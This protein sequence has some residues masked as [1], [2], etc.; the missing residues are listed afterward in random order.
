MMSPSKRARL[1]ALALLPLAAPALSAQEGSREAYS[2][3]AVRVVARP[4]IDGVLD[5]AIWQTA[6]VIDAFIQQEPSEGAPA[7]ERTEVRVLYDGGRLFLAVH[8]FD[9]EPARVVASEMRRDAERILDEDNFQVILDTF[10]D[11]RSAYMFAVNPLG[12]QLDQQVFDEGGRDRR[13]SS[14]AIN[15]NWDGVWSVAARTTDDGWT[16][17]LEIP[18]VNL[19]FPESD[20]QSWGI[21]FMRNIRRKNEEVYWAPIPRAFGLTRVSLAGSLN[22]LQALDRGLDLRVKPYV[23]GG[24]RQ[25]T[26]LG[27]TADSTRGEFGLDLKYGVTA[28]LNLDVTVNTDFAQ[29]EV[30]DERVNLTRFAL[31][32]PE[33]REFFLENAGQFAVGTP[34][35][36]GR[37]ADLF[38]SRRIGLTST[39]ANVPILG[40]AR[41]TGKVGSNNIA[42]M[43][44]QTDDA[45][46]QP[47]ENF[48]VARYSRD[49]GRSQFGGIVVNK[50]AMRSVPGERRR[51]NR[52]FAADM[53]V[54]VTPSLTMDGFI[55]NT[56]TPGV[57]GSDIG[58]HF[59][60]GWLD[61]SWRV[62]GEFT[63]LGKNFNPEVGFVPR[64]DMLRSKIH[65]EYNPRPGRWGIRMM[66]PMTNYTYITDQ[67]GRKMSTHWHMMVGTRFDNGAYLNVFHNRYFERI[68]NQFRVNNVPIAPGDYDFHDWNFSFNS[69][70]ARRV[71]AG[72]SFGPQTYY[73]GDRTDASVNASLRVSSQLATS[74]SFSRN[75]VDLPAGSF[76][77]DIASFQIDYAY[78][79]TLSLRSLTQRNSATDQWS[80]SARLRYIFRPGSDIYV[81]YDG[82]RRDVP[83]TAAPFVNEIRDHQLL[84]KMTYLLSF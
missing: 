72:V 8:A 84:I 33:K 12:A 38:F 19:R 2:M 25:R 15:R 4:S 81:V 61:Q 58:G 46:G 74:A 78:S 23:L 6:S 42:V 39:G 17:E 77:V 63:G 69:N 49:V 35:S 45:F 31:F 70:P 51:F 30:D 57:S 10:Q 27:A 59:R 37:I 41:L 40:G 54:V 20:P 52:T 5:E 65:F 67:S 9:S 80:T 47:G 34:N 79:P 28:S 7:T 53:N 83:L 73:G 22:D 11:S 68:D 3:N 16:A 26:N 29:A 64:N 71:A 76:T 55:A 60:A 66:E 24:G 62:Y 82:L 1:W 32:F 36:L 43:D 21:N 50:E 44:L 48:L 18:M 14:S 56:S 13:A 75:E